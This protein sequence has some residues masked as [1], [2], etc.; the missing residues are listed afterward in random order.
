MSTLAETAALFCIKADQ[1]LLFTPPSTEA[2]IW[3]HSIRC[4]GKAAQPLDVY[5][6]TQCL[7]GL[8]RPRVPSRSTYQSPPITRRPP[9]RETVLSPNTRWHQSRFIRLPKWLIALAIY[10]PFVTVSKNVRTRYLLL[11]LFYLDHNPYDSDQ[12]HYV[13][14]A[15]RNNILRKFEI[16]MLP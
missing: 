6:R 4:L 14:L 7:T 8:R 2:L 1:G 15:R 12:F 3:C 10:A 13:H 16:V 9:P 11:K 5:G